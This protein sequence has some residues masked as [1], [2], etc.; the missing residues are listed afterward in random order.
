LKI[1]VDART[2]NADRSADVSKANAD[3]N[4]KGPSEK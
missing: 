4:S 3:R 2:A 1:Q